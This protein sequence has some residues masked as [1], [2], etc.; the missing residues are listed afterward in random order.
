MTKSTELRADGALAG[1]LCT[2]VRLCPDYARYA[3]SYEA[4]GIAAD[5]AGSCGRHLALAIRNIWE[6]HRQAAV[7]QEIPG[8]WRNRVG[9]GVQTRARAR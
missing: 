8:A 9:E 2:S 5:P 3:V 6:G 7:I 4:D 1:T